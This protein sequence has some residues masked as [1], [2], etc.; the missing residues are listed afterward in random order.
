MLFN[1][2]SFVLFFIIVFIFYWSTFSKTVNRRKLVLLISSYIFYG[3]WD[4]RILSLIIFSTIVDFFVGH[5]IFY[6]KSFRSRKILLYI[7]IFANLGVLSVFKYFNFFIEN[8]INAFSLIGLNIDFVGLNIIL[9]VGISFYT[10]QTLSY[11][12]DIYRGSLKPTSNLLAFSTFVA[13]FPQLV[14]GP[15]ER[16]VHLLPQFR[17]LN[18][19][20]NILALKGCWIILR[21]FFKKIVIAD[22]LGEFVELVYDG[23]INA[24][25]GS[26]VLVAT[27]LFTFQIYCDFS[28]YS[29]IAIGVARLFGIKLNN[30]FNMPYIATSFRDFWQRWHISLS[31]W[32]RDYVYISIGG[33]RNKMTR[34]IIIT[35]LLSGLWHGANWTFIFWGLIHGTL[36]TIERMLKTIFKN[37]NALLFKILPSRIIVFT[38]VVLSWV[39]FRSNSLENAIIFYDL[40]FFSKYNF[41]WVL[42]LGPIRLYNLIIGI[43]FISVLYFLEVY[44]KS[45][46]Q[47]F[48]KL[49]LNYK[50]I[51]FSLLL[52]FL[53]LFGVFTKHSSFIY[54]QF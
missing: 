6:L 23:N 31:S 10:F 15:I 46:F 48:N 32:F 34:N 38:F 4:Y 16:A 36:L 20:D 11:T 29:D 27:I 18:N 5:Y 47:I 43:F 9:P 33:N 54:F 17:R 26:V 45:I 1:S 51:I 8:L 2:I 28:G 42:D 30:N 14:A 52:N 12:I 50:I 39:F 21:G 7:S 24:M 37:Y 40:I 35:F 3:W 13:F 44:N 41:N 49:S 19:F 53:I 25:D 22:R